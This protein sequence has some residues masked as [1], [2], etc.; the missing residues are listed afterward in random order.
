MMNTKDIKDIEEV[1]KETASSQS[2]RGLLINSLIRFFDIPSNLNQFLHI[3]NG[4]SE[5]S[6]R[7]LDWLITNYAKSHNIVYM[8]NV[9]GIEKQLNI[10]LN[11]KTQLKA[12]SKK[13]FDPFQRRERIS[14]QV[15][16]ENNEKKQIITTIGQL[17]FFR[18]AI[19]NNIIEYAR[20][21]IKSIEKDMNNSI[22]NR[23]ESKTKRH[24]R[25]DASSTIIQQFP[26]NQVIFT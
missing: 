26:Q 1:S 2:R 4:E 8:I 25:K 9:G 11:Y 6:L 18:W 3:I 15:E 7:L 16:M 24:K 14:F 12:Y 19:Q 5:I 13:Q 21:N 17:N 22:Q 20:S 10:Y 23:K